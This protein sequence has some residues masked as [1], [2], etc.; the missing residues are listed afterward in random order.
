MPSDERTVNTGL[1]RAL[2]ESSRV[3]VCGQA[4][5]H[6]VNFTVRDMV[7]IYKDLGSITIMRDC[8]SAVPGF[9]ETG[10][11]FLAEMEAK[12]VR[13]ESSE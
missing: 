4:L 5:S 13:V 6:C 9:E 12:G 2:R 7:E 3:L 1:I 10:R 8:T 11:A